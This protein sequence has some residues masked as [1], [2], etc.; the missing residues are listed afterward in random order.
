MELR[1]RKAQRPRQ[2]GVAKPAQQALSYDSLIQINLKLKTA[3]DKNQGE[4]YEAKRQQKFNLLQGDAGKLDG[5]GL[6]LAVDGLVDDG[7]GQIEREVEKRERNDRD[8]QD[9]DLL[10]QTVTADEREDGRFHASP[11]SGHSFGPV[12]GSG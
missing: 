12:R 11:L 10:A 8:G 6:T 9:D 5:K 2:Q 7:L 4:E 1:Q 3:V